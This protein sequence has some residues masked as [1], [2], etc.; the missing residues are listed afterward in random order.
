MTRITNDEALR[1]FR[2]P[3]LELGRL[4]DDARRER[5]ADPSVVTYHIDRNINYTNQCTCG[6]EFCYFYKEQDGYLLTNDEL[7]RR[8]REAVSANADQILLQGGLRDDKP[9]AFYVDMIAS[10]RAEIP[11][12]H[13][14]AFSPPEIVHFALMAKKSF[15]EILTELKAAGMNSIPGG[16]AEILV[17]SVRS[18]VSPNKCTADEWIA[19]MEAAHGIGMK[20]SATMMFNFGETIAD[21]IEHLERLRTLQ[22]R[23]HGFVA[24]IA[25]T[26]E[27][28]GKNVRAAS[29]H[30]GD[31]YLRMVALARLYLDN[32]TNIQS[33]WVTQGLNLGQ[34]ALYFGA[35]DMGSVMLEE[36]V[37]RAAG[38]SHTTNEPALRAVI[39]NAGF[40]PVLRN[41]YY[42]KR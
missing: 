8:M 13:I 21:R 25:W 41:F 26:Y 40:K 38:V 17:D 36:N 20:S 15:T 24:F 19:V 6:C 33:S 39:E 28:E 7:T 31:E 5:V 2:L 29:M 1:L 12:L 22:D 37:V 9:F 4:A 42:E 16:G 32:F 27:G 30:R 14:H 11:T 35:N 10:L 23:T 18:R 34:I 3:L